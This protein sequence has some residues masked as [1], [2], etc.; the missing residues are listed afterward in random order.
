M[1]ENNIQFL[2]QKNRPMLDD[3]M[4]KMQQ[5]QVEMEQAKTRMDNV[6][7]DAEVEGGLVK[8]RA[9]ANKQITEISISD[10]IVGDK[11]AIE[12]L[13]LVAM[14]RVLEQAEEVNAAEMQ[15]IAAQSMGGF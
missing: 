9:T 7:V 5:A 3:L 14:N 8:V 10:D 15:K 4:G 2:T 12:D 1:G 13:L 11:E 6:F